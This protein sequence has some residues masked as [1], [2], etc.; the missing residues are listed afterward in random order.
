M[1]ANGRRPRR[2]APGADVSALAA[3]LRAPP[4]VGIE[5]LEQPTLD[6]L[7]ALIEDERSRRTHEVAKGM[8]AAVKKLPWPIRKLAE[9][10]LG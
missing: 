3:I 10:A 9:R 2:P 1:S 7:V 5:S 6:D 4:P 8:G